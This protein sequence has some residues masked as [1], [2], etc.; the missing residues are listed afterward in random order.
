MD[1]SFSKRTQ[2]FPKKAQAFPKIYLAVLSYFNGV[3]EYTGEETTSPNFCDRPAGREAPRARGSTL[4]A[5]ESQTSTISENLEE[6]CVGASSGPAEI[7][8]GSPRAVDACRFR[9]GARMAIGRLP[10]AGRAASAGHRLAAAQCRPDGRAVGLGRGH[11]ARGRRERAKN[12]FRLYRAVAE[13]S[14]ERREFVVRVSRRV[15][16]T[17]R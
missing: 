6:I 15:G 14:P 2:V 8:G 11:R 5:V 12:P 13:D 17:G 10:R 3:G 16:V 9:L 7:R 4:S 1:A